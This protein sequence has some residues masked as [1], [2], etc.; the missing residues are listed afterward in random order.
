M[1]EGKLEVGTKIKTQRRT[2]TDG[3]FSAM[4]NLSWESCADPHGR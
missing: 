2:I 3:D 4:V 1:S